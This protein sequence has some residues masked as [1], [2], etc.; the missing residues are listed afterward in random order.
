M[1]FRR[2]A[3]VFAALALLLAPTTAYAQETG[4]L[5]ECSDTFYHG[6]KRLGPEKLPVAGE[7]GREL[8]GYQRTGYLTEQRFLEAFYDS[9]AS[10]WRYPPKDG[11]VLYPDGTPI[12][13][14]IT[15]NPGLAIDRF[16]SEYGSFLAPKGAPYSSRSIPP[17]SLTSVPAASCNYH[18]Y[19][20][21][22]EFKVHSGPIA[23]WFAQPGGGTQYQ[24][25]AA[26]VP[27]APT[28][29]NVGWL[30]TNGFLNRVK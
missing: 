26:L 8:R 24:L 19:K 21:I 4:R 12:Q 23:P 7:V 15:L 18:V 10:S 28:P 13:F 3:T 5:T 22:K 14:T 2:T 16:G 30:I 25:D 11:Y 9:T 17:Q 20:V 1:P 6:D 27:G 29:I